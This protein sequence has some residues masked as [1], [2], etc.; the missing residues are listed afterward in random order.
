MEGEKVAIHRFVFPERKS[1]CLLVSALA[2]GGHASFAFGQIRFDWPT[3]YPADLAFYRYQTTPADFDLDGWID[4]ADSSFTSGGG[5]RV[6]RITIRHN[7]HGTLE[8]AQQFDAP[9]ARQ[10]ARGDFNGDQFPDLVWIDNSFGGGTPGL[11]FLINDGAGSLARGP[12]ALTSLWPSHIEVMDIDDDGDLDVLMC[13]ADRLDAA[14]NDGAGAFEVR[15]LFARGDGYGVRIRQGDLD[16]DGDLDLYALY[17]TG[18]YEYEQK[19][20]EEV[21]CLRNEGSGA[22]TDTVRTNFGILDHRYIDDIA[23]GDVDGD[24]DADLALTNQNR[25]EE[26]FGYYDPSIFTVYMNEA[27]DG[28][29]VARYS[30]DLARGDADGG[31]VEI[32]DF[33]GDGDLD[34]V[35]ALKRGLYAFENVGT[36]DSYVATRWP[37]AV[38]AND[39]LAMLDVNDDGLPDAVIAGDEGISTCT[40]IGPPGRL[41][42]THTSAVRGD[43]CRLNVAGANPGEQVWF[44]MGEDEP[45]TGRVLPVLGGLIS[46]LGRSPLLLGSSRSD[47]SGTARF[48]FPV[49]LSAPRQVVTF[50]AFVRRGSGGWNSRKSNFATIAIE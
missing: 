49:P 11:H 3:W 10:L 30:A 21:I 7:A 38:L 17:D 37:S 32:A 42:L 20:E 27:R 31:F 24:G 15:T 1:A 13:V 25:D 50:Q 5:S 36:N 29:L 44:A 2:S 35:T 6:N 19:R 23:V 41:A 22:Y 26:T 48:T 16:A 12:D 33:D 39:S 46:E 9:G 8:V 28:T 43:L 18:Y 34:V 45:T 14:L 4:V 40:S 47:S